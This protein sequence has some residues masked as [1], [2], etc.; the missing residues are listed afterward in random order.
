MANKIGLGGRAANLVNSEEDI[1]AP[2]P[3][4]APMMA[5]VVP[6]VRIKSAMALAASTGSSYPRAMAVGPSTISFNWGFWASSAAR[7]S[8]VFLTM[9]K[10]T[11]PA[12]IA[13]RNSI[14]WFTEMPEYRVVIAMVLRSMRP[15]MSWTRSIFCWVGKS[16]LHVPSD[17]SRLAD[18][19]DKR[20]KNPYATNAAQGFIRLLRNSINRACAGGFCI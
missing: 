2:S 16:I 5:R 18:P 10:S 17:F 4:T 15:L 8:S 6:P 19:G 3:M 20:G 7:D 1:G 11:P 14:I 9:V 12:F 13:R